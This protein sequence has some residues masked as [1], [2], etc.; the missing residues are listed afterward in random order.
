MDKYGNWQVPEDVI[1]SVDDIIMG[2]INKKPFPGPFIATMTDII[3]AI[4]N[5]TFHNLVHKIDIIQK[6]VGKTYIWELVMA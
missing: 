2:F 1:L 3:K 4:S 6:T 5:V